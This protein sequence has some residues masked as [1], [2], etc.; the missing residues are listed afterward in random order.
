MPIPP[1]RARVPG[2]VA[3]AALLLA[4]G[5]DAVP[6]LPEPSAWE[7]QLVGRGAYAE[8]RGRAFGASQLGTSRF[9][10]ELAGPAGAVFAWRLVQGSCA[11]GGAPL[12][13][14]AAYPTLRLGADGRATAQADLNFMLEP[15][16]RYAVEVRASTE[17][18]ACG[19]L[20]RRTF[21]SAM[22]APTDAR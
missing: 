9:V 21:A 6:P 17:L 22:P 2:A 5:C 19:D 20:E 12:G 16:G 15:R 4:G 18:A 3:A 11:T 14:A 1:H 7:T 10:L 8:L 13:P